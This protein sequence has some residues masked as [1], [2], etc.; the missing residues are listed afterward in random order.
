M[1]NSQAEKAA[2]AG[3]ARNPERFYCPFPGCNRSFAE[4]WRLKVSEGGGDASGPADILDACARR[5]LSCHSPPT[6]PLSACVQVHYR[7]PP[8]IRCVVGSASRPMCCALA[9][10]A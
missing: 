1:P 8:D 6:T 10:V 5:A 4:L 9:L 2:K 7:A 3:Q